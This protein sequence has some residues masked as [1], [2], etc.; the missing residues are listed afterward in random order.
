MECEELWKEED[1]AWNTTGGFVWIGWFIM[2]GIIVFHVSEGF[3][4]MTVIFHVLNFQH[5][6][7]SIQFNSIQ[8]WFLS[9][10]KKEF[11]GWKD[12]FDSSMIKRTTV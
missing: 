8:N 7:D 10:V 5:E 2:S 12:E 9:K 6:D 11:Q 4:M 1:V 3:S